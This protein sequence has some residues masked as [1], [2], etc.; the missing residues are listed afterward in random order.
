MTDSV[1]NIH[2]GPSLFAVA[3]EAESRVAGEQLQSLV[4]L[5]FAAIGV[6]GFLNEVLA[7]VQMSAKVDPRLPAQL[8]ALA[9][10][11]PKLHARNVQ[12]AEKVRTFYTILA[13]KPYDA[14]RQP[15]Q[16]FDLLFRIRNVVVHTR[17]ERYS[18]DALEGLNAGTAKVSEL[19]PHPLV[20]QLHSRGLLVGDRKAWMPLFAAL[21]SPTVATW[22]LRAASDTVRALVELFP[23]GTYRNW[24]RDLCSTYNLAPERAV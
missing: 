19:T 1:L 8:R 20:R 3:C 18:V 9:D 6:E 17:P 2:Y 7:S 15:F 12:T 21:C 14:G 10:A 5:V 16:D 4:V 13:D 23:D 11:A 24:A 22:A